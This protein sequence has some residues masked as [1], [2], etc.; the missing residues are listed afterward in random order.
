[1]RTGH[2]KVM[3]GHLF[4]ALEGKRADCRLGRMA[5]HGPELETGKWCWLRNPVRPCVFWI[6]TGFGVPSTGRGHAVGTNM[7]EPASVPG[8]R[9]S[10]SFIFLLPLAS[11]S[12]NMSAPNRSF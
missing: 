6:I 7:L 10:A 11:I 3:R 9:Y 5:A 2:V 12:Y 4:S 1:M 8:P